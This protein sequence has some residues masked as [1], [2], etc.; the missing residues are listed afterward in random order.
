V[1]SRNYICKVLLLQA[2][3]TECCDNGMDD[4]V[5]ILMTRL[6]LC[7]NCEKQL[8][9]G[10]IMYILPFLPLFFIRG[11]HTALP[12]PR[13]SVQMWVSGQSGSSAVHGTTSP[14]RGSV[15]G[16]PCLHRGRPKQSVMI[17]VYVFIKI[18]IQHTYFRLLKIMKLQNS[19][20]TCFSNKYHHQAVLVFANIK[21]QKLKLIKIKII[22][23][24]VYN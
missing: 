16:V 2:L 20:A 14:L 21:N 15:R 3:Q 22:T 12:L 19:L 10:Q 9:E 24:V 17:C 7:C 6:F 4:D 8:F 11:Q 1:A 18:F 13:M 5:E 23:C